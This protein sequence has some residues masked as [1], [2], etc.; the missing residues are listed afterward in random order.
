[1]DRD[2]VGELL[3]IENLPVGRSK[4]IEILK[5]KKQKNTTSQDNYIMNLFGLSVWCDRV[6]GPEKILK[7][8]QS[9][10]FLSN[11][12]PSVDKCHDKQTQ[13]KYQPH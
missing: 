7:A 8:K 11:F 4:D 9:N 5:S 10:Q 2:A 13:E 3:E 6:C 1:M 12:S